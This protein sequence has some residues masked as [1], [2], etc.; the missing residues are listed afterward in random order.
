MMV[1]NIPL[2]SRCSLAI[3]CWLSASP[4]SCS[5]SRTDRR[6]ELLEIEAASMLFEVVEV[7]GVE[8]VGVIGDDSV[9]E[10][11]VDE[12]RKPLFV[13]MRI[14]LSIVEMESLLKK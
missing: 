4:R 2:I 3:A 7:V 14:L 11:F 9:E 13:G 5:C 1:L 12:N 8:G 6:E 10:F